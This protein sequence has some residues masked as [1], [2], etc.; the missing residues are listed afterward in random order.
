VVEGAILTRT[1]DER[2]DSIQ[3]I[4]DISRSNSQ[5]SEARLGQLRIAF[6]VPLRNVAHRM[7]FPVD[8]NGQA[9]VQAREIDHEAAIR[10]LLSKF[11]TGRPFAQHPPEQN[12]GQGHAPPESACKLD[13][14][15]V[16]TDGPVANASRVGPS[17]TQLR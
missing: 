3:I 1:K 17:T 10:K 14:F 6:D 2:Q 8:L 11:Q 12:L 16:S 7:H 13:V 5:R 4:E 9:T 15:G